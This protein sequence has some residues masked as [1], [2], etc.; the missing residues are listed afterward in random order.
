M[1]TPASCCT[2]APPAT[3]YVSIGEVTKIGDMN[4]YLTGV[5]GS[6]NA[7][8]FHYDI[9][10][11]HINTR[12]VA[13]ILASHGY[14]VAVPD[15]LLGDPWPLS[16]FPPPTPKDLWD[17]ILGKAPFESVEKH[18]KATAQ[19]LK[20][21]GSEKLG[22][23]GFCWGGVNSSKLL[24]EGIYAGAALVHTG[25][26]DPAVLETSTAP[27]A[28]FPAK[29]DPDF[30]PHAE[31]LRKKPFGKHVVV[32]RF[33]DVIHGFCAARADFND[34][35]GAKRCLECIHDINAFFTGVFAA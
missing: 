21:E 10:G 7:I 9:F 3:D 28:F 26:F 31:V 20:D 27:V 25:K 11:D 6:K 34:E 8:V 14:R 15:L 22:I 23:V 19:L 4:V 24:S 29:D 17:H 18:L 13:D 30:T 33:D 16:N 2:V 32:K 1:S 5:K 35:L 12:H